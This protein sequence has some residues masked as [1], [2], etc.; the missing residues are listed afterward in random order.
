MTVGN[1]A[2]SAACRAASAVCPCQPSPA[3]HPTLLLT[4]LLPAAACLLLPH[5][6]AQAAGK[7]LPGIDLSPLNQLNFAVNPNCIMERELT[8]IKAVLTSGTWTNG[9][10]RKN[11]GT[12]M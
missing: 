10:Y 11:P 2:C 4:P 1:T 12:T 6:R 8:Y 7:A 5:H 3:S 9:A